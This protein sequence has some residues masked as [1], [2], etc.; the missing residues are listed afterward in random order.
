MIFFCF[1]LGTLFNGWNI[2]HK[3]NR[4]WTNGNSIYFQQFFSRSLQNANMKCAFLHLSHWFYIINQPRHLSDRS[5][6]AKRKILV[7]GKIVH[8]PKCISNFLFFGLQNHFRMDADNHFGARVY[9]FELS[10]NLI[11]DW[12]YILSISIPL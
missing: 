9:K 3:H 7:Y 2:H 10:D 4:H 6:T 12:V 5:M 8:T 1:V 11:F